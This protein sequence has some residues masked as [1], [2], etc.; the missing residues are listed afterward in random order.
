MSERFLQQVFRQQDQSRAWF[1]NL[2]SRGRLPGNLAS[3]GTSQPRARAAPPRP[4]RRRRR[5][6]AF[7]L[8]GGHR[9]ACPGCGCIP[10]VSVPRPGRPASACRAPS[11]VTP[12]LHNRQPAT[13]SGQ[14][15]TYAN[16]ERAALEGAYNDSSLMIKKALGKR[17]SLVSLKY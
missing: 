5:G 10:S 1:V 6:R 13:F 11:K 17:R 4:G 3:S 8:G 9:A 12:W 7:R 14:L 15:L 16:S 2:S